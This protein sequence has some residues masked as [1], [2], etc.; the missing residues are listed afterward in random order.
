[1][2]NS[3]IISCLILLF[4]IQ[5]QAQEQQTLT[6]PRLRLGVEA[7]V[8]FLYG[9]MNKPSQ[10][11]ESRS[12][13]SDGDYDF[14]CGFVLSN[15]QQ[16]LFY[17]GVKPEYSLSKRFVVSSGLRFFAYKSTI[18][19]DKDYFLWRI[20]E[21]DINTNYVKIEN[22]YQK[23][24]CIGI[25]LEI[26]FF[27]NEKDYPVRVYFVFG[28]ALNFV[29]YSKEEVAFVNPLMEKYSSDVLSQIGNSASFHGL[30]Y[31]GIGL[32]FGKMGHPFGRIEIHFPSLAFGHKDSDSFVKINP[33]GVGLQTCLLIPIA[34][35]HQLTY[36]VTD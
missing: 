27:P 16:S 7:G 11:R 15:Y 18:K 34:K 5:I 8:D 3:I 17:V 22:I 33:L 2:K 12:Y 4:T 26:R 9:T 20:S 25:P 19:S 10:I 31:A 14:H 35:K 1:M 6:M 29:V 24:Y 23:N 30:V 21:D 13:Y 36:T 32:K 28:T